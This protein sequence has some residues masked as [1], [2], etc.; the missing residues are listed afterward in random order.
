MKRML[1]CVAAVTIAAG[2][3]AAASAA[4]T[5]PVATRPHWVIQSTPNRAVPDNQLQGMSCTSGNACTAVGSSG[6]LEVWLGSGLR[7]PFAPVAQRSATKAAT[8]RTL[9]E[10]WDG[11]HWRIEPTPNPAGSTSLG[12]SRQ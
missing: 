7:R 8:I 9:A 1:T 5:V 3:S 10:R 2:G 6:P 11:A 12:L 4:S